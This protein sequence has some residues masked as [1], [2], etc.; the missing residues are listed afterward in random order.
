MAREGPTLDD[1]RQA[2]KQKTFSPV[3]LFHGEEDLL[4]EEATAMVIAAALSPE[5]RGFN[6]DILYGAEADA[7]DIAS[8]ASSFPMMAARRVVVVRELD[9][10]PNKELL[11]GYL[12]HPSET[13]CL[14]L[15]TV[16]ADFRKKPYTVAKRNGMAIEFKPLY[17]S[18][19]PAWITTQ[20]TAQGRTI[21]QDAARMLAT[22]VGQS[23]REIRNEIEKLLLYAGERKEI[24]LDD[25]QAVVGASREY[26]IFELQRAVGS[27]QVARAVTIIDRMLEAGEAPVWIVM[28]LTRFFSI[29][30]RVHEMRRRGVPAQDQAAEAGLAPFQMREFTEAAVHHDPADVERSFSALIDADEQLKST[31]TDPRLVM[32]VLVVLLTDRVPAAAARAVSP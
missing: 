8:H 22:Y 1:L 12:E 16:K 6:L 13:T 14:I 15:Q 17:D 30:W 23:L 2:L 29:L 7:R 11:S 24:H 10:L 32:E 28:M 9:R 27:R 26:N 5:E 3:Y 20:V 21:D 4:A 25:V 31:A 18:Q 19:I